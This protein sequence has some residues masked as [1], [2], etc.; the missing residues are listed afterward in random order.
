MPQRWRPV[1]I[2]LLAAA[3]PAWAGAEPRLGVAAA[4]GVPDGAT[5]SLVVAP[6]Q[7]LRLGAGV[8]HNGISTGVQGQLSLVPLATWLHPTVTLGAGRFPAGDATPLVRRL[9]GD[10]TLSSPLLEHVGYDY[11]TLHLGLELG[12]RWLSLTVHAGATVVRGPVRGLDAELASRA[13]D[14][15]AAQLTLTSD[16]RATLWTASA[17]IGLLVYLSP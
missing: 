5:A 17:R 9:S 3:V 12:R 11:A 16:P 10:A 1:W 13:G 6:H 7:V 14:P 4:V 8:A 15:S 2:S